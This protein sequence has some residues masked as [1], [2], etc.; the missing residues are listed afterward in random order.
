MLYRVKQN[1]VLDAICAHYYGREGDYTEM[2]LRA[3]PGLA[4]QGTY[5]PHGL[6]I[7]LPEVTLERRHQPVEL[8][9]GTGELFG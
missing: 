9:P 4:D 3:N 8:W 5:L 1:E 2:V 7:N 6:W